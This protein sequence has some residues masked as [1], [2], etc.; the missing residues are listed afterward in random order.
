M[1]WKHTM[2][3]LVFLTCAGI[4]VLVMASQYVGMGKGAPGPTASNLSPLLQAPEGSQIFGLACT[5]CHGLRE[6]QLQR[7][8]ADQW[9]N[10]VYSMISRG[11]PLLP[12]EIEPLTQYLAATYGTDSPPPSSGGVSSQGET[13][14]PEGPGRSILVGSCAS[15]HGLDLPMNS[16]K[17]EAEWKRTISNMVG[18]GA[19]I[20][21]QDQEILAKYAAEHFGAP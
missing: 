17:S 11:A 6:T 4:A 8:T 5:G 18:F 16:R 15:C 13:A 3:R 20:T 19:N 7:K 12:D 10:T 1:G 14:L 2:G 9:R 21:P